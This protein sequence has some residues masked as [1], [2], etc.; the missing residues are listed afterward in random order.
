MTSPRFSSRAAFSWLPPLGNSESLA[1]I[2]KRL[3]QA[4][5]TLLLAYALSFAII[6]LAPGDYLDTLKQN[7]QIS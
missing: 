6:Q 4:V 1:Y 2:V 3:L 7:P 5:V